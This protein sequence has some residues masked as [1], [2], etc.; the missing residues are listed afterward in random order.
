MK[1][2]NSMDDLSNPSFSHLLTRK[3]TVK[4][5]DGI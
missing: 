2:I 5:K 3:L 4:L 1:I